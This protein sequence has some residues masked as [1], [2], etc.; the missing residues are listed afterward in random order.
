MIR[1]CQDCSQERDDTSWSDHFSTRLCPDCFNL[2]C[3]QIEAE[4]N[5][6]ACTC[7]MSSVNSASIDPP[8][9]IL[10]RWCPLHGKDP[11]AE[12]EKRR[13]DA[14]WDNWR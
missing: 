7:R 6:G 11:D 13:D 10:D 4:D 5:D 12:R 8:E 1:F 2:R 3:D 14:A 9:P